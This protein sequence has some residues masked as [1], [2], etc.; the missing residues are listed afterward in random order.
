MVFKNKHDNNDEHFWL[1]A[2]DM[3]AALSIF[4]ILLLM[5][6]VL[7][8][9]TSKDEVFTPLEATEGTNSEYT[10]PID[11]DKGRYLE[12]YATEHDRLNDDS[13]GGDETQA[14]TEE[15]TETS[16]FNGIDEGYSPYAAVFVTIV[17]AETGNTIKKSGIEFELYADKNGI[18]GLQTLHT[19]YPEKI[20][21]KKYHTNDQGIFYL[22]EKISYGW[23]SL[24]NLVAPEGYYAGENTDFEIDEGWHWSEPYMVTVPLQPI[25]N[26]IRIKAEDHDTKEPV[27]DAVYS[28]TAAEDI[29]AADGSIR[30]SAGDKVD[31]ITTDKSGYS[32][33][34]ELYLGKYNIKQISAPGFYAVNSNP[35]TASAGKDSGNDDNIVALDCYKTAVTVRLTDERTE[36]PIEGAVYSV[37]GRDDLVT[38]AQGNVSIGELRKSTTYNLVL[39]ELPDGYMTKSSEL[40]FTVDKN[41]L[42]DSKASLI[43]EN[44]AYNLSLGVEVKDLIFGRK[45]TGI[46]L[47]LTDE[48]GEVVEKWTSSDNE[49]IITG[50]TAGTYYVQRDNDPESRIIAEIKDTAELQNARMRIWDTIDTFA[51]LILVG[52]VIIGGIVLV[53]LI[54]RR[55]KGSHN[56]E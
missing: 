15:A 34:K 10:E 17:D 3:M 42:I 20:E 31:E 48:N 33:T 44:T 2:T 54:N 30:Y 39:T 19:Y 36:E 22:P 8:L 26:I 27:K 12:T 5:L 35:V 9:N 7:F 32:E 18:G 24:H 23:Y 53:V 46:D 21:Y 52:T 16:A 1:S 45:C 38:D 40:T 11:N 41:G 25:K 29:K 6:A 50:L 13:G 47:A 56:R 28:V 37:E 51:I 43:I 14:P 4:F 55:K 49:Y